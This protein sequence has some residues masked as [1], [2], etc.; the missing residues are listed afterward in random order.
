[1]GGSSLCPEVLLAD[2]S[3]NARLSAAAHTRLHRSRANPKRRKKDQ[4]REDAFHRFQQ[5]GQHARA[6]HLQAVF[7]R[8]RAADRRRRQGGQPLYRHHRSRLEDAAGGRARPLPPHFLWP[9]VHRRTLLRAVELRHGSRRGHGPRRRQISRA[10]ERDGR[11]L[12]A[13]RSRRSRIRAW[14]WARSSAPP[15]TMAATRLRSSLRP[16]FPTWAR[17][18]S[19]CSPNP[20]AKS[21]RASSRWTA[22]TLGAPEVYGKNDRIFAYLRLES[23]RRRGAGR[24]GGSARES[25]ASGSAHRRRR[26]L[27]PGPGIFPLGDCHRGRGLDHRHQ[28]LQSARRR[29]QQDR[30][31]ATDFS[32]R[33]D[34]ARCPRKSRSSKKRASS[35]SPTTR[36]PPTLAKA[37]GTRRLARRTTCARISA[38]LGAGDYFALLGYIEMNAEHEALLQSLAHDG[39]RSQTRGDLPGFRAAL[40]ALHGAGLQGRA[41]QRAC[42]CKSPATMRMT[43]R[44]RDRS[45]LSAW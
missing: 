21:A 29:S 32:V 36:T 19:S 7:F 8:A 42:S 10:H 23:A 33:E 5:I 6:Q 44:S 15:P 22:K 16:E 12:R 24:Q 13:I 20:P 38:R 37:A 34:R 11:S 14:C 18:W 4:P 1:M 26:H 35:C 31:A 3:A 40:P 28:R 43:C 45:T 2:V 27:Q 41:E 30:D 9:A 25:R 17:G 39:A